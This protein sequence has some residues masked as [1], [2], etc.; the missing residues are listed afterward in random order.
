MADDRPLVR[1]AQEL[2]RVAHAEQRRKGPGDVPYFTHLESVVRRLRAFG[3]D[4]EITV[5]AGYLHDLL[6]DCPAFADR[7][8]AEMPWEVV[9]LVEVLTER[10]RDEGGASLPKTERFRGYVA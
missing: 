1:A 10:K 3:Y 2:A 9:A 4:D 7:L 8:R 5:A 6:E